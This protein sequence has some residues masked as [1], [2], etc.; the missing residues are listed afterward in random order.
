MLFK[1][2]L[3]FLLGMVLIGMIGKVLFP[4]ALQRRLPLIGKLAK[5]KTC[6]R[7]GRYIIG[8]GGCDCG[9]GPT[10]KG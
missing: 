3:V 1:T 10:R 7:C 2:F 4:G 9:S 5:P 6:P 8:R